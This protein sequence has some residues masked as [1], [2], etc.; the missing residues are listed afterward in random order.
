MLKVE[1]FK[2]D[3]V[4]DHHPSAFLIH[5][6]SGEIVGTITCIS[7]L[8]DR[9]YVKLHTTLHNPSDL[10]FINYDRAKKWMDNKLELLFGE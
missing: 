6:P 10:Q 9:P 5:E 3:I 7:G 1:E 4:E 8:I 2:W